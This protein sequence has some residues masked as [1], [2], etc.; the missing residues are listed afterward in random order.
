[1]GR[2]N[3]IDVSQ[4]EVNKALMQQVQRFPGQEQEIFK[5]YQSNPEALAQLR[6]PLFEDKIIDFIFDL[7]QVS[8]RK[9]APDQLRA[10]IE[11]DESDEK[12]PAKKK[13]AAKKQAKKP[14]AKEASAEAGAEKPKK[15]AAA[16][17]KPAAKKK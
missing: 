10:E 2:I 4:E 14:A 16:K 7:A 1:V 12:K 8:E 6:A 3:E 9:I 15:A 13:T 5:F 11:A 17:K